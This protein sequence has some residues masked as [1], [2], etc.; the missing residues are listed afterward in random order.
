[1]IGKIIYDEGEIV[2]EDDGSVTCKDPTIKRVVEADLAIYDDTYTPA[3]GIYGA[4]FLSNLAKE[5]GG[6][7]E[8]PKRKQ[9]DKNTIY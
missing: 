3:L 7:A 9:G 2:L 5:I 6:K 4:S 1:M 8:F